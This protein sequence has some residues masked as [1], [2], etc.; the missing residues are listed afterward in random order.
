MDSIQNDDYDFDF[1]D[2]ASQD[3]LPYN[4]TSNPEK[5][6]VKP[7]FAEVKGHEILDTQYGKGFY[8]CQEKQ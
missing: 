8:F 7:I 2:Q 3:D 5:A 6:L 1:I 4:M